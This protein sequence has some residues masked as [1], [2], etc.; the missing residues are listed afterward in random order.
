MIADWEDEMQRRD[1]RSISTSEEAS[2]LTTSWST[3]IEEGHLERGKR[4]MKEYSR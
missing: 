3:F 1:G 4:M 2:S